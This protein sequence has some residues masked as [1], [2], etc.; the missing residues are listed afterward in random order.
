MKSITSFGN[1]DRAS[2]RWSITLTQ[3][4]MALS[5]FR[6][7]F[8]YREGEDPASQLRPWRIKRDNSDIDSL[9]NLLKG[10]CNLFDEVLQNELVNVASRKVAKEETK[11]LLL[12]FLG[13]GADLRCKFATECEM[14]SARFLKPVSRTKIQN[15]A[16]ENAKRHRPTSAAQK[17]KA[18]EGVRDV[19]GKTLAFAAHSN[20]AINLQHI[21]SFPITEVPLSLAHSDGTCNKTEKS[22][23]TK[24]LQNRQ[25]H[26]FT[27]ENLPPIKAS[28]IDGGCITHESIMPHCK[29]TYQ[30]IAWDLLIKVCSKPGNKFIFY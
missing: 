15:F 13:R 22:A 19:F 5:E 30:T 10:T 7:L 18:A 25:A 20:N 8:S 12:L 1:S 14:D 24:A 2:R 3:R 29:S 9:Y 26:I 16:A 6:Q 11:Q 4:G 23:L 17:S 28:L 27:D 21:L